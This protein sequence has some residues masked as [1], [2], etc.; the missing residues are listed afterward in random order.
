MA[1]KEAATTLY[2]R[3]QDQPWFLTVGIGVHEG[4]A[5][6]YLYVKTTRGVKASFSSDRWEGYPVLVKTMGALH[7]A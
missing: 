2:E 1:P 5:A 6:I 3:L 4:E 7:P